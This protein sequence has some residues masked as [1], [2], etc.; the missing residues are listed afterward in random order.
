MRTMDDKFLHTMYGCMAASAVGSLA[1]LVTGF[2]FYKK[3]TSNKLF[4]KLI[5]MVSGSDL[6]ASAAGWALGMPK[7]HPECQA[8]GSLFFFFYRASWIWCTLIST[9]LF[10][11]VTSGKTVQS[12]TF[13]QMNV[14][15]WSVNILI[16]LLPLTQGFNYG[17]CRGGMMFGYLVEDNIG[18]GS[19]SEYQDSEVEGWGYFFIP[20]MVCLGVMACVGMYLEFVTIP[21]LGLGSQV[22]KDTIKNMSQSLSQ[23]SK[24][25]EPLTMR[26]LAISTSVAAAGAR[27][28]SIQHCLWN[29]RVYVK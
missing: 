19:Y 29:A 14:I 3:L 12:L 15:C 24:S 16:E 6:I 25:G 1:V 7:M 22:S 2:L 23:R 11:L 10:S 27:A 8:Q 5:M 13:F 17:G 21:L 18:G 9:T 4:M 26:E 28:A 20:L